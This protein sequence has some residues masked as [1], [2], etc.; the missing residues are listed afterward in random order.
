MRTLIAM[1]VLFGC[2][3]LPARADDTPRSV[4][5][6]VNEHAPL[7]ATDFSA[8]KRHRRTPSVVPAAPVAPAFYGADPSYGPGT[9]QLRALQRQGVCVID[10]GYGRWRYCNNE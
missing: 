2:A 6:V 1:C 5:P 10:E 7:P 3:A 8:A 4:S 9:P